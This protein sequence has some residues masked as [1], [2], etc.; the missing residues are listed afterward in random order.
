MNMR[1]VIGV[2]KMMWGWD[3]PHIESA[4]WL[5]PRDNIRQVMQGVPE[6]E[7]RAILGGNAVEAYNLDLATLQPIADRVGPTVSELVSV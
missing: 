3:F 6:A 7:V 4:D 1:H 2:D 5:T